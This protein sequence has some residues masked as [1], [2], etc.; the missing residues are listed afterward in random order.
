MVMM[1]IAVRGKMSGQRDWP[2]PMG[3]GVKV[4]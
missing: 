3:E 2:G 4:N 1:S